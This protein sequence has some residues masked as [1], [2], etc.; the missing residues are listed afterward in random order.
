V[1]VVVET[2]SRNGF[3]TNREITHVNSISMTTSAWSVVPKLSTTEGPEP[4]PIAEANP[5]KRATPCSSDE[6]DAQ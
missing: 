1:G 6:P 4:I 2:I 3:E 5:T